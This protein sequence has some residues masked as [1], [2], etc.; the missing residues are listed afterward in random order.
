MNTNSNLCKDFMYGKCS[1]DVCRFLHQDNVCFYYW[2][3]ESCKLGPDCPKS[4]EYIKSNKIHKPNEEQQ[5]TDK[6]QATDKQTGDQRKSKPRRDKSKYNKNKIR[7]TVCFDPMTTPVDLRISYDLGRDK[8]VSKITSRELLLVPNLFSDFE[9][10]EIYKRLVSE[11]ENCG[12]SKDKLLKMWH[13]D[14]HFI[15]D[16]HLAWKSKCPTFT[17]VI[18]RIKQFFDMDIK[19]TRFNWYTD[20]KQ[21]KPFHHDAAAVKK[22]KIDTQNFTVGIS[23]GTTREAAFENAKTGTTVSIPQPDGCIYAFAKDTNVIW[24]H[25]ILQ[26]IPSRDE[27]R[28]SIIA[29]GWVDNQINL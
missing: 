20:T 10:G 18:D 15:A 29:W 11:I 7:N 27:G 8:V 4:H 2:K 25:G 16:D 6:Q 22:D 3:N 12:I 9:T 19:A 26:D 1:R 24:R 17:L 23:F 21:W 13:G 5:T 28:I 14:S